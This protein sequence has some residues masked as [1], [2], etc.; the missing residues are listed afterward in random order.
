MRCWQVATNGCFI[1]QQKQGIAQRRLCLRSQWV[2]DPR[3]DFIQIAL[4]TSHAPWVPIPEMLPWDA[5]GDGTV[6]NQWA[7][8]GPTPR[9]LWKDY[10]DV[11]DQYRIAIDYSL[12]ATLEHVA[13]LGDDAPL[14]IVVGSPRSM[15]GIGPMG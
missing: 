2:G 11:R 15:A 6:F 8:Q 1:S 4:I 5:L 7:T 9:E 14:V 10:D 12:Q 13:R 3:N